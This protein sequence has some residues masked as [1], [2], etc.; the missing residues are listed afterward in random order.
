LVKD[1]LLRDELAQALEPVLSDAERR[2]VRLLAP[3][4]ST[5]KAGPR[6]KEAVG[7]GRARSVVVSEGA[8]SGLTGDAVQRALKEIEEASKPKGRRLAI[9]WTVEE[10]QG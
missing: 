2:A 8:R 7:S 5:P 3:P 1:A 6:K 10:E 9:S 4:S